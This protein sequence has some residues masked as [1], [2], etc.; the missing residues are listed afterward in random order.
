MLQ[1]NCNPPGNLELRLQ[2]Y[3]PSG[4]G[5]LKLAVYAASGPSVKAVDLR[6]N[7]AVRIHR[8]SIFFPQA[9]GKQSR[10]SGSKITESDSL[11]CSEILGLTGTCGGQL[12]G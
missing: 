5:Y 9:V 10:K 8:I 2:D 4:G 6:T 1:V 7:G 11:G 3:R 12:T